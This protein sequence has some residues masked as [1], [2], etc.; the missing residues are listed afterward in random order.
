MKKRIKSV[1]SC[2]LAVLCAANATPITSAYG[3][4]SP[5]IHAGESVNLTVS[6]SDGS[7][8]T[9]S[10]YSVE[11]GT[12]SKHVEFKINTA[13]ITAD[14]LEEMGYTISEDR[15]V[16]SRDTTL[17][18]IT[19]TFDKLP[20]TC[21]ELKNFSLASDIVGDYDYGMFA[22]MAASI[23]AIH[24]FGINK[25]EAYKMLDYAYGPDKEFGNFD[26]NFV[27]TQFYTATN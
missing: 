4:Y 24:T 10:D 12:V 15:T 13:E 22:P 1:L 17:A 26:K 25:E 20:T 9:A 16:A 19:Y 5:S 6:S 18:K 21:E 7:K 8:F 11:R 23:I 14:E 3:V 2:T 27:Q